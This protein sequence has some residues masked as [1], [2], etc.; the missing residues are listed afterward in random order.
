MVLYFTCGQLEVLFKFLRGNT[1]HKSSMLYFSADALDIQFCLCSALKDIFSA[2]AKRGKFVRNG[3]FW[4]TMGLRAFIKGHTTP[5]M[6]TIKARKFPGNRSAERLVLLCPGFVGS[7]SETKGEM[8]KPLYESDQQPWRNASLFV[9]NME[10]CTDQGSLRWWQYMDV[11]YKTF[12][13]TL[14]SLDKGHQRQ[15][16]LL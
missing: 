8:K 5:K 7:I 14:M 2:F 11:V 13:R 9:I 16:N 12:F 3:H 1:S 15:N 10:L 4:V 6:G